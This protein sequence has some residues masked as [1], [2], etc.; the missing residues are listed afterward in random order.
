M[1][2]GHE[3]ISVPV[4]GVTVDERQRGSDSGQRASAGAAAATGQAICGEW[5]QAGSG[6]RRAGA[7]ARC[8]RPPG[9]ATPPEPDRF[10]S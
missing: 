4:A 2:Q 8:R 5:T 9:R 10:R 7:A 1:E 6:R 3:A